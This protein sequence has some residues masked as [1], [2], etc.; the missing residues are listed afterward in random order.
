MKVQA[1]ILSLLLGSVASHQ[2]L[3]GSK[4]SNSNHE[5]IVRGLGM[6][7]KKKT[8]DGEGGG[9]GG[10]NMSSMGGGGGGGVSSNKQVNTVIHTTL[11]DCPR[12]MKKPSNLLTTRPCFICI[13]RLAR[14][15]LFNCCTT[16]NLPQKQ[17]QF[18]LPLQNQCLLL[19]LHQCLLQL[20]HQCLLQLQHQC[21]LQSQ[22]QCLLQCL[23]LSQHLPPSPPLPL[24]LPSLLGLLL[25][26]AQ[27][28]PLL[29]LFP[30]GLLQF[31]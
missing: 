7:D 22:H 25:F 31:Q 24:L 13:S 9:M 16:R 10:K 27:W 14:L 3:R 21:L 28:L 17:H 26:L 29:L 8:S 15:I 19:L 18:L 4:Q 23:P 5:F 30:P 6:G 1:L 11:P 2:T 12:C 20:P